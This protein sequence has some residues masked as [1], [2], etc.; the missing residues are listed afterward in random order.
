MVVLDEDRVHLGGAAK[1]V[2]VPQTSHIGFDGRNNEKTLL[3]QGLRGIEGKILVDQQPRVN[4]SAD[5]SPSRRLVA[6]VG[7]R[8]YHTT[9]RPSWLIAHSQCPRSYQSIDSRK[10]W[11]ETRSSSTISRSAPTMSTANAFGTK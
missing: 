8:T 11:I 4:S 10:K 9:R 5:F 2:G 3:A 1:L 6:C 7:W